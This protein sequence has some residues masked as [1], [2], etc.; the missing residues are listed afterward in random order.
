MRNR[1]PV[2]LLSCL[3]LASAMSLARA[4]G[5]DA[6]VLLEQAREAL[7][8]GDLDRALQRASQAI[9]AGPNN[10]PAYLVRGIV[11]EAQFKHAPAVADFD[12]CLKLDPKNADAYNHRGSEQFKLGRV[13][14]SL[15]DFDR[16]LELRPRDR[17]GHWKRGISLYYAGRF[18]EGKKQFEGY[19]KVDTNDV[20]NAVWHFLCNARLAGIDKARA[21]MLKIGKDRR[22]PMMQ[23]YDLYR[24]KCKPE[25]VLAAAQAGTADDELRRRQ[26]FYAH[27]YLG[28]Y[29]EVAGDK[30]KALE[31]LALAADRYRISHYM[32]DVARVHADLLRKEG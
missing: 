7:A 2:A 24:G 22:V 1:T 16:Y 30:K 20:E 8:A 5:P 15:E 26:L 29:Y 28:I 3:L 14:E 18:E 25:D 31:H 32:G 27:L 12:M 11:Y 21:E 6:K 4:E 10:A 13:K 9:E 17:P 23:V 19:E